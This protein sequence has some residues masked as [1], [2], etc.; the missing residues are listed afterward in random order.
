M[1]TAAPREQVEE[2]IGRFFEQ[3]D[4]TIRKLEEHR[5]RFEERRL[6]LTVLPP[7]FDPVKPPN[8]FGGD[9]L[10]RGPW[11]QFWVMIENKSHHFREALA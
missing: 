5:H 10:A 11:K 2:L 4:G 9:L 7:G 8:Y 6:E 3:V 1:S